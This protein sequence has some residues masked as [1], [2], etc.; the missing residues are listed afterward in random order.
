[1]AFKIKDGIQIGTKNVLNNTGQL[2]T[3]VE[4]DDPNTAFTLSLG[5]AQ[6]LGAN[7][8]INFPDA[9]GTIALGTIN[10]GT[11][12]LS[13]AAATTNTAVVINT[14]TGFN[15]NSNN[16]ITY[17]IGVG[18]ALSSL[19]TTMTGASVGFLKKTAQDTYVLDTNTYL[20]A[21]SDTLATVTS[22]G[23]TTSTAVTFS[24][25]VTTGGTGV[26]YNGS[27][28]G[29]TNLRATAAAGSTTITMPANTGTMALT[30]DIANGTL[31]LSIGSAAATS[32]AITI[33][34]GTGFSA[35]ASSNATYS[36]SVGP[37]LSALATTMTG[38]GVGFLR[39]NGEDTYTLDTNTYLTAEADTLATVTGRGAT[40]SAALSITSSTAST[41]TGTGALIVTGGVGI[42]GA[43]NVGGAAA[44]GGS[45]TVTGNLI[46]NGTTTTVNSTTTT[47]D[48]PIITL[49]GDTA[50]AADDN[51]DRGV[52]FRWHNGTTAKVGFFG[53]DDS[54]G[55]L[56][57]IP[58]AT[59][60]S[61]VFSGSI[62]EIDA[63]IAWSNVTGDTTVGSN[64]VTL[65]NPGAV[66][67]LRINA[68]NTVSTLDATTFRTAIG[69]GTSSTTGTVTNVA[70]GTGLTGG[71]ITSTGTIAL[72]GQA[73]AFHNLNT[74]GIVSRTA[75]DTV[76]ARTIT[77]GANISVTNGDGVAG[78]PTIAAVV[79]TIN[80]DVTLQSGGVNTADIGVTNATVSTTDITAIDS[81]A[82]ATFRAAKYLVQ[83]TQ[84]TNYQI[85]EILVLHYGTTTTMTEY[86]VLESNGALATI[87][88]DISSGNCRLLVT[89]NSTSSAT[90]RV[91]HTYMRV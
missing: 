11:L 77:A 1:M 67:F 76:V 33:S 63:T 19:A 34:S 75:A 20:T 58:D 65:P 3:P 24:G 56:T 64:L 78:N 31:T 22:R 53:F 52:E 10:T 4:L 25:G 51:K 32:N 28:S 71:P 74:N 73:L 18:P 90:I 55:K 86:A 27:T 66:T 40:T 17:T 16:P 84:G 42:G 46:V 62:G 79:S 60:S 81:F 44:V 87:T 85:S 45:L 88:S 9:D 80:N 72:T 70:T 69:A 41:T 48:D 36:I 54:T 15:A 82:I 38:G 21:E 30:S 50:P 29:S 47:L 8:A 39:K 14:G 23:A 37:A 68:D 89:M 5:L 49:G 2:V 43:L 83:I 7:R 35:N 59:N 12:T 26:T 13:T 6:Q 91:S 57:F 61:E